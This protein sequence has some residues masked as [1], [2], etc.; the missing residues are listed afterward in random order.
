MNI[1]LTLSAM[2]VAFALGAFTSAKCIQLGLKYQQ[3]IKD[4]TEPKLE[5]LK[6]VSNIIERV[7]IKR[8]NQK[9]NDIYDEL[10]NGGG[11]PI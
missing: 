3:N 9:I 8:E 4:G 7:E 5:P 10:M 6:P 11:D 1:I 2:L